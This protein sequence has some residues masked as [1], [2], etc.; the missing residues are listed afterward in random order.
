MQLRAHPQSRAGDEAALAK[1]YVLRLLRDGI[2]DPQE[3]TMQLRSIERAVADGARVLVLQDTQSR[4][5]RQLR[6]AS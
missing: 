5:T 3:A 4:P 2:L 6:R 1:Q